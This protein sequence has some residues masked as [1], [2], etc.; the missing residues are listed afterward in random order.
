[1]KKSLCLIS[2]NPYFNGGISLYTRNLVK[3]LQKKQILLEITWIYKGKKNKKYSKEGINYSEIKIPKI[4]LLEEMVFNKKVKQALDKNYFDIIN[5]HALWGYWMKNYKKKKNQK[6]AHTYHGVTHNYFKTHLRRFSR[7]K[8]M[9]LSPILE[10]G[11]FIEKPPIKKADKIICV[12]E[13][14]KKQLKKNYKTSRNLEVIR[15]GVDLRDFKKRNKSNCRKK[16]NLEKNKI[17]GLYVGRG[18]YW[19]KGLD[20]AIKLGEKIY[21]IN[22]NFRLIIVGAEKEK[23]KHLIKKDFIIYI[24]KISR[25]K[26]PLFYNS[27]DFLFY[28]SRYDGGAPTLVVS[29]AMA[30]GCPIIFSKDSATS[31]IYLSN[32]FFL[33]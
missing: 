26:I 28:L 7:I 20:R 13:K 32:I 16:L 11:Y 4:P 9:I 21:K 27:S 1:M 29:E 10:F 6:I 3:Y 2:D 14:V 22:K 5:S 19:I 18:G 12:S 15:T 23:I 30:S 24:E 25:E 31:G 17:Y 33:C 8:R